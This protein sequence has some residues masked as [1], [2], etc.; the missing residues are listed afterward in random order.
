MQPYLLAIDQ[1]TTSSR[2]ILYTPSGQPMGSAQ[3]PFRQFFPRDGWVEHDAEEIWTSVLDTCRQVLDKLGVSASDVAAI[4]ITNQ[5]ETTV[6]WDKHTGVPVHNAIVWQ[7]RRTADYCSQFSSAAFRQLF[8]SKTGLLPDPYFSASKVRWLLDSDDGLQA[9]ADRGDL[10]FGTIDSFLIW[11]LTGGKRH[12]TDA[13]NASRTLLYNIHSGEWDEEL[14]NLFNVPLAM[15]PE[16]LDCAAEFGTTQANLLGAPIAIAGVAGDQ[17]AAL[18]GQACFEKG[19]SKST[20][21]T[22]C[23]LIT[24]TGEEALQSRNRL[25]TTIGYQLD[26]VTTYALEGSIFMAG[27]TMQWLKDGL[28]LMSNAEESL[29]H[30]TKTGPDQ[31]VYLVPAFTGLGAPHWNPHARG[32]IVGLTRDTGISD[33]I[34]AGL[35]SVCYQTRDLIGAMRSDGMAELTTIRVDGGMVT[36]DWFNQ[37]L[38]DILNIEVQRPANVESTSLGAAMLAGLQAGLFQSLNDIARHWRCDRRYQPAMDRNAA[39]RLYAGWQSALA[40]VLQIA[41]TSRA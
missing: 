31:S 29:E 4:G 10:L 3:Q 25:L 20:Y 22:G 1:G 7:D 21:G 41:E 34:T 35:Q 19:M 26:G 15:L 8:Q 24:N 32:A 11:R 5:R 16:V 36:N 12:V 13:T 39:N 23:F 2:A 40:G 9:R 30:A 18:I 33:I 28:G 6:V 17:Q 27:A 38:A 37:F 14:L